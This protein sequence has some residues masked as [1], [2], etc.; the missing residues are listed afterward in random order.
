VAAF[1]AK[2]AAVDSFQFLDA[3]IYIRDNCTVLSPMA[4]TLAEDTEG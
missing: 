4:A 3:A 1:K 2:K